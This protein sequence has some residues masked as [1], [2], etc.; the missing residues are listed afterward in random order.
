MKNEFIEILRLHL[1]SYPTSE[2]RDLG[3]LAYQSEFGPEHIIES[4]ELACENIVRELSEMAL[5]CSPEKPEYIG[6]GLYR[7]PLSL[8]K[9]KYQAGIFAKMMLL[10][11]AAHKG[12]REGIIQKAQLLRSLDIEGM[13]A[14]LKDWE[15]KGY[16]SLRHSDAY[17]GAYKPHYRLLDAR[18]VQMLPFILG[19]C[20]GL[21]AGKRLTVSIDGRCGS[22]KTSLAELLSALFDCNV[23]HMD[24]YYLPPYRR[25]E[26]WRQIP[27]GNID[28]QRLKEELLEPA[29]KLLDAQYNAYSCQYG[30]MS[31][32]AFDSSLPLTIV[33]GSYSQH[34]ELRD[35]YDLTLFINLAEELRIERLK[36]R[37]GDYFSEFERTWIPAEEFYLKSC[38]IEEKADFLLDYI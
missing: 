38:A 14:W 6:G 4:A 10:T 18:F 7:V 37:E 23:I 5:P 28:F 31:P 35:F 9:T 21:E 29:S 27:G 16:C 17:R 36:L 1:K 13:E 25:K 20:S 11:A 15:S 22:G 26:N 8:V 3:K 30:S 19:L 24:D 32:K 33:E 2:P 34:P 12:S